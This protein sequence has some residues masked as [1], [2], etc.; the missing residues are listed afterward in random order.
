MKTSGGVGNSGSAL[1]WFTSFLLN[2]NFS[3]DL[4]FIF[5][6]R[7]CVS[8]CTSFCIS[9]DGSQVCVRSKPI[10]GSP[11]I[12]AAIIIE[13]S[14]ATIIHWRKTSVSPKAQLQ[15]LLSKL[16]QTI[17][18]FTPYFKTGKDNLHK[19]WLHYI[20]HQYTAR[21]CGKAAYLPPQHMALLKLIKHSFVPAGCTSFLTHFEVWNVHIWKNQFHES[22]NMSSCKKLCWPLCC[23]DPFDILMWDYAD[24]TAWGS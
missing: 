8:Y 7:D 16:S 21:G 19:Q 10:T 23:P 13:T 24:E 12:S 1:N 4:C 18:C 22:I 14:I 2:I 3:T 5:S 17:G 20:L 6:A 15:W 9:M 11:V